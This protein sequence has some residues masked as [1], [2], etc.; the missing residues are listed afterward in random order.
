MRVFAAGLLMT[1]SLALFG[2]VAMKWLPITWED[3]VQEAY[4]QLV[5][6]TLN[7]ISTAA[8]LSIGAI[9]FAAA[10]LATPHRRKPSD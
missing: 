3:G 8:L 5:S 10:V 4:D 9:T 7:M 2:F 6:S 1:V